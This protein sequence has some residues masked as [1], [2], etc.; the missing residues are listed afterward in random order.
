LTFNAEAGRAYR[1]WIRGKAEKNSWSN[2]SVYY[3]FSGSVTATGAPVNRIG[4]AASAWIG[5][6]D[7]SGCSIAGWGWQDNGYGPGVL[8]PLVYFAATG[9]QTLRIQ[10][11][12]DG[13]SI[14]QI[15]LS[16]E[17]YLTL[18]PGATTNDATILPSSPVTTPTAAPPPAAVSLT[19]IVIGAAAVKGMSGTWRLI[20]D[21]SAASGVA[22]A[23]PDAGAAKVTAPLAAPVN[24][25]ELTFD[26]EAGRD[27]R[28]WLR[29]RA[30]RDS[31]ANDSV[32]VQF[33]GSVTTAGTAAA[34]IGTTNGYT[35]NLEDDVNA[36]VSGWGWQD[37][38]YG[39]GV[40][41]P[42]VRFAV[43]GSQRIRIQIRED[44]FR[45]DQIV[46]SAAQYIVSSPGALKNDTKSLIPNP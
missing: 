28:L 36:G 20:P 35:I 24:Y 40:L 41:G 3:Q 37:N 6:E 21:A 25:V 31:W 10:Q 42:L 17:R 33:D 32:Y 46:L 18:S 7:C 27:Y 8:G 38:G 12:E 26:A 14:D 1:L 15:V 11:R 39:A 4:S 29:G 13:I 9:P 16:P 45:F 43:T 23:N 44:G 30:E 22:I 2:D 19:E 34:R 5:I